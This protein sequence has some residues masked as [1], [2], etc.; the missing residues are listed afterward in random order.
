MQEAD[1]YVLAVEFEEV[2]AAI[3]GVPEM[4]PDQGRRL[5]DHVRETRPHE[6]L[7]IGTHYG[8]S[9]AYMGAAVKANGFGRL[10]T[11]DHHGRRPAG[12][13]DRLHRIGLGDVVEVVYLAHSSYNWW[14]KDRVAERTGD[15]GAV[16]PL[17]DFCFLDGSHSFSIDG[18]AVI[19]VEKLLRP[20][21][22]LLLDDLDWTFGEWRD[23]AFDTE[24]V[25]YRFS[26]DE[27]RDPHVRAVWDVVVKQ[28][29]SF[30]ELREVD[31]WWGW[32]RKGEGE[33]RTLR[34]ETD[35]QLGRAVL[36]NLREAKDLVR[37]RV[38]RNG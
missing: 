24:L 23:D 29:P 37:R 22:W 34:L 3:E 2:A 38:R 19:L 20:G 32:A 10:T 8:A 26:E 5:Y 16:E 4:T 35:E 30:T 33:R 31:G 36:R 17:Y 25:T 21:A 18:L 6:I 28:H 1:R 12:A 9:A 15:G 11:L 14:L 7:E 13:Q 27:L